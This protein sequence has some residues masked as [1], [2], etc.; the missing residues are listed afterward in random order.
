MD[1]LGNPP[2][3]F[4]IY[5]LLITVGLLQ[6]SGNISSVLRHR[7]VRSYMKAQK[8]L[9]RTK[10]SIIVEATNDKI[11]D[12]LDSITTS[13]HR[14]F[15]VIISVKTKAKYLPTKLRSYRRRMP[16]LSIKIITARQGLNQAQFTAKHAKGSLVQ[17]LQSGD[18]LAPNFLA[19]AVVMFKNKKVQIINPIVEEPMDNHIFPAMMTSKHLVRRY[20]I[21]RLSKHSAHSLI[22]RVKNGSIYRRNA[23]TTDNSEGKHVLSMAYDTVGVQCA[24]RTREV[25]L[26][27]YDYSY[28]VAKFLVK[29]AAMV[30]AVAAVYLMEGFQPSINTL[31]A[32]GIIMLIVGALAVLSISRQGF[33]TKLSLILLAPFSW[34]F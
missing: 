29:F 31:Q 17:Y 1:I 15:E 13:S 10:V 19:E 34:L 23:V 14:P 4:V 25:R 22:R 28:L 24:K 2:S 21:G 27:L 16:L 20:F 30:M 5:S 6:I 33:V 7:R 11:F 26:T 9:P 8:S 18:L 3:F 32:Y 12:T